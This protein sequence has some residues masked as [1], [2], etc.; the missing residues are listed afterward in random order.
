MT[1]SSDHATADEV[2]A[3]AG[4]AAVPTASRPREVAFDA[5]G[6]TWGVYGAE[7]DPEVLG[8]AIQRHLQSIMLT[9]SSVAAAVADT[10]KDDRKDESGGN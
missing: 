1:S 5:D 8:N 3:A 6:R 9:A 4:C 2:A 10:P 7:L